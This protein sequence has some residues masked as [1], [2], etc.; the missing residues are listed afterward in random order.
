M[1]MSP[2]GTLV[3]R[4]FDES[5]VVAR[6]DLM[7]HTGKDETGQVVECRALNDGRPTRVG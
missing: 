2:D 6:D 3:I 1:S 4:F 7:L 5:I